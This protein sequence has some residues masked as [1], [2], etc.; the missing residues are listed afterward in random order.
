MGFRH[1]CRASTVLLG[2]GLLAGAAPVMAANITVAGVMS[3]RVMMQVDG[4]SRIYT[5]GQMVGASHRLV[6]IGNDHVIIE[7]KGNRQRVNIGQ[8]APGSASGEE[9]AF[10]T[11][12]RSGHYRASGMIND[13][14]V[15]FLVDTG[16]TTVAMGFGEARRLGLDK[17]NGRQGSAVTANGIVATTCVSLERVSLGD[18]TLNG[19]DACYSS[20]DMPEILLGMS[21][22]SRTEMKSEGN[23]MRLKK[24]F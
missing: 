5:V 13:R 19:V 9:I 10:L 15:K 4:A 20:K 23:Q 21:F 7:T 18:I 22:L 11:A 1:G 12:D 3:G 17:I 14:P 24:R 8:R 2:L 16:A 6:E